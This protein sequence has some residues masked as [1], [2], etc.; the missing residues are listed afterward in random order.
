MYATTGNAVDWFYSED[1]NKK[2]GIYRSASFVVELRETDNYRFNLPPNQ[3][4]L[5]NN[6]KIN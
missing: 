3:V 4:S 6:G 2:N 5:F 1:A